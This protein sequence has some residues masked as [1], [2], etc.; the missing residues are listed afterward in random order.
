[1]TD[2]LKARLRE[3]GLGYGIGPAGLCQEA[4]Q[5]IE[6]LER[7]RDHLLENARRD[8]WAQNA[9]LQL[10]HEHDIKPGSRDLLDAAKR[11]EARDEARAECERWVRRARLLLTQLDAHQA[12]TG[13]ELEEDDAALVA[14]VRAAL[15]TKA[16][17]APDAPR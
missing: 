11:W 5:R 10:L 16:K 17:E 14:E 9:F 1:M 15:R 12:N 3:E 6:E 2:D 4:V 13:E 8:A 7:E